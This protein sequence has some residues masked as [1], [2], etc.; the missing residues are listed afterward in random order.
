M[1]IPAHLALCIIILQYR[2]IFPYS[3]TCTLMIQFIWSGEAADCS[4]SVN[5]SDRYT[6]R[7]SEM[8]LGSIPH[9]AISPA[10]LTI[11]K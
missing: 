8:R 10:L 7:Y 6:I 2:F 9:F 5:I 4:F 1:L 3:Q 11:S